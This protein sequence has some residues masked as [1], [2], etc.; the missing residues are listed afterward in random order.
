MLSYF[1]EEKG[2]IVVDPYSLHGVPEFQDLIKLYGREAFDAVA[3]LVDYRSFYRYITN[4]EAKE[5]Q[6]ILAFKN[7]KHARL[8]LTPQKIANPVW[9]AAEAKY[10]ELNYDSLW[11]EYTKLTVAIKKA[12][13]QF[14]PVDPE[15]NPVE[16]DFI[17]IDAVQKRV[18]SWQDRIEELHKRLFTK[19]GSRRPKATMKDM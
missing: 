17:Q 19:I 13:M 11:D 16:L 4:R 8:V 15:G 18:A 6:V 1:D 12:L 10:L 14:N 3:L 2:V 7:N 9:K 5:K